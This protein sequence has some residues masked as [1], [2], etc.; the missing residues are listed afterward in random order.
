MT[1]AIHLRAQLTGS[2]YEAVRKIPHEQLHTSTDKGKPTTKGIKLL[3]STL[4]EQIAQEAPV[5]VNELFLDY[6]YSA[7]IWR[8]SNETMAQYL[9]RREAQFTRLKEAS[10]ETQLSDNLKCI[11]LAGLDAKEQQNILASANSEYGFKKVSHALRIQFPNAI[12][13]P[14]IRKDYLRETQFLRR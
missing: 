6:F 14:V 13:R 8:K 1:T 12:Q 3:L 11:L 7:G 2:A 4:R 10:P 5:R 9:V